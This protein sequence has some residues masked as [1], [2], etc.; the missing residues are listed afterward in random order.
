MNKT[1]LNEVPVGSCVTNEDGT[2]YYYVSAENRLRPLSSPE[3]VR[4]WSFPLTFRL[5]D[6]LIETYTV[7]K[8]MGFRPNTVVISMAD[9]CWYLITVNGEKRKIVSN[10]F[11]KEAG[12]PRWR[13][14]FASKKD[15]ELHK[16]GGDI[17]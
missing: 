1:R 15:L 4:S 17:E 5:P 9:H 16:T 7:G 2:K 14:P 12:L 8:P 6:R 11:F 3:V 10:D 13:A